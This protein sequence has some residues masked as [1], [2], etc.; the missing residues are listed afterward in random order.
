M[1]YKLFIDDE[2]YPVTP[3]WFIAR[4]SYDAIAKPSWR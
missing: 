1:D 2:R 4:N 3:D